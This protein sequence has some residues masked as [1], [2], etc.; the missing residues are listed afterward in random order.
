MNVITWKGIPARFARFAVG[1][2]M[3]GAALVSISNA[4]N[5]HWVSPDSGFFENTTAWVPSQVPDGQASS[6]IFGTQAEIR[7]G[8]LNDH[9][10]GDLQFANKSAVNLTMAG[11]VPVDQAAPNRVLAAT[12][13]EVSDASLQLQAGTLVGGGDVFLDIDQEMNVNGQLDVMDGARLRASTL[14]LGLESNL[15]TEASLSGVDPANGPSWIDV[16][17]IAVGNEA[18]S[19]LTIQDG[20]RLDSHIGY[21][22]RNAQ[23]DVDNM[24]RVELHGTSEDG[25]PSRWHANTIAVGSNAMGRLLASG[26]AVVK[27][28]SV[29]LGTGQSNEPEDIGYGMGDVTGVDQFGNRSTFEVETMT[30]GV[31]GRG[32]FSVLDG[33]V[34]NTD[35][36]H[37][38]K[39]P[40]S[41]GTMYLHA[42][43]QA[44]RPAQWTNTGDVAV[45]GDP[46]TAGGSGHLYI[47][48]N[49]SAEIGGD[50][51]IWPGSS[52]AVDGGS[53]VATKL[54][55]ANGG[56]LSISAGRLEFQSYEGPKLLHQGGIVTPG[57]GA[58]L[59]LIH[60]DFQQTGNAI[61][62]FQ[63]DGTEAGTSHD[64]I[65]VDGSVVI[66]GELQLELSEDFTP[67]SSDTYNILGATTLFGAYQNV[68]NGQR[69]A[70]TDGVGSF[71]VNYGLQSNFDPHQVVLSEYVDI[72]T[73]LP[74]DFNHDGFLTDADIDL[75]SAAVGGT[76]L[77]YDVTSNGTIDGFDREV[78]VDD[79][80]G[81]YFGD[82]KLDANVDF[83]DFLALSQS[84]GLAGGWADGDFDGSGTVTFR[85][86]LV[87]S[88]NFGKMAATE[89]AE[90]VPEPTANLLIVLSI[91]GVLTIRKRTVSRSA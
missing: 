10:V 34:A 65:A 76:N 74:G 31:R 15:R 68:L 90:S 50:L 85:D 19:Q 88:Q 25:T 57:P 69:L 73:M 56:D 47:Q 5:F 2:V 44:E 80:A 79:L 35:E 28:D 86:F 54:Q 89:A 26:G 83:S 59:S 38:A 17:S 64:R 36:L 53:L 84:F 40:G 77:L 9:T 23:V 21:V 78:W 48:Q 3:L 42:S 13:A 70:T 45:G 72:T 6:V 20:A 32:I 4:D 46:E 1:P 22:G 71:V 75:L 49:S 66:H 43:N 30:V 18:R 63:I 14:N 24:S 8:L 16:N 29:L 58:S 60:S 37:L 11:E 62:A 41:E 81:T 61:T 91:V 51:M 12:S 67:N 39:L 7:V 33:A 27:A 82:A 87:L 52:V 55:V